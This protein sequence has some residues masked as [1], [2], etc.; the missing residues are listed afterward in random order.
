MS[1][2]KIGSKMD[3]SEEERKLLLVSALLFSLYSFITTQ[4]HFQEAIMYLY[5]LVQFKESSEHLLVSQ[6]NF[7]DGDLSM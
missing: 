6:L 2:S 4:H 5:C 7:G 1:S 3:H